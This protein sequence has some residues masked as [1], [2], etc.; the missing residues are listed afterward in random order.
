MSLF[1]GIRLGELCALETNSINIERR[2][3]EIRSTVQRIQ[4]LDSPHKTSLYISIPKTQSSYRDVPICNFLVDLLKD[5][6]PDT[7]YL[8]NG[9]ALME[10][11]TYQ[12]KFKKY[13][14]DL[15]INNINF[16]ALRHTFATNCIE[17]GM[18]VKCLSEILG[19]ADVK[20]TLNR[21]VHPSHDMKIKQVDNLA[22]LLG[23]KTD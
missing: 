17:C 3:I 1:T 23:Q 7:K 21:Y 2:V 10:P 6:M 19:H 9:N 12:Y 16:H 20:T 13:M 14:N 11:R 22:I 5:N 15:S 8:I 18:D 4:Y